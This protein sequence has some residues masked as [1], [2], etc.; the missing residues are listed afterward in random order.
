MLWN[1]SGKEME[2]ILVVCEFLDVF[3]EELTEIPPEEM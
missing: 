1:M 3:Q 2:E